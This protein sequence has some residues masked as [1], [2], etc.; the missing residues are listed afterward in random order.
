MIFLLNVICAYM[1]C[2][3]IN[4]RQQDS[5]P[6][7]GKSNGQDIRYKKSTSKLNLIK[8]FYYYHSLEI[9]F[10]WVLPGKELHR[11]VKI[12]SKTKTKCPTNRR[13]LNCI[14]TQFI[15]PQMSNKLC[16]WSWNID[17]EKSIACCLKGTNIDYESQPG[18]CQWSQLPT[19]LQ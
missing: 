2:V 5:F 18:S 19:V 12:Y 10:E 6:K 17:W 14:K 4:T 16:I 1:S 8:L 11:C 3:V 13:S 7:K 15:F 9:Y